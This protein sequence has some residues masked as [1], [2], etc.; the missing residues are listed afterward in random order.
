MEESRSNVKLAS[1]TR[2][3]YRVW[4]EQNVKT[5][6]EKMAKAQPVD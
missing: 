1:D 6:S 2:D 4:F 3:E 5:V